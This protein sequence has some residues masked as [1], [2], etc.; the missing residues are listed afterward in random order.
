MLTEMSDATKVAREAT[1]SD[2]M[3]GLRGVAALRRLVEQL[4][5]LQIQNA[6]DRGWSWREI[7]AQLGVSHQAVHRKY[8]GRRFLRRGR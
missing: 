8:A 6:R 7:A 2:P 1:S 3:V 4:E 5:R